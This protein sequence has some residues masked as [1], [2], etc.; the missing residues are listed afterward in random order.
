MTD[1]FARPLTALAFLWRLERSDGVAIG[2]TSHDRDLVR[3]GF[4][5]RAAPGLVP[6]AVERSDG[7][8]VGSV[9]L[10]GALTADALTEDDFRSG[11]WDGAG[12]WLF[13]ADWEDADAPPVLIARGELGAVELRDGA[14]SVAL[15]GP[16]AVLDAPVVEVTSP[17]C[18]AVLGDPRCRVDLAGRRVRAVVA[19]ATGE[20]L[21][22]ASALADGDFAFG[23]L[24]WIDGPNAG[25]KTAI[26]ANA[27]AAVTLREA[28]AFAVT[29]AVA[30]ELVQGCDKRLATC[31]GRFGNAVNFQGEPHL[32]GDDLLTRY[33]AG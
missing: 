11:R 14:F 32:P 27:G 26:V 28:P 23:Q 33:G 2:F 18:R 29:G 3:G 30:V 31:A 16:V 12:L 24:R 15:R 19:S 17:E 9:E 13:A 10:G 4:T 7:L 25:L 1:W 8:E 6:S 21:T 22:L 20:V 5:Y